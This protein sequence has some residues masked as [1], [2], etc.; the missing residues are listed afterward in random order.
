M[1]VGIETPI[2][3]CSSDVRDHDLM[4]LGIRIKNWT[5]RWGGCSAGMGVLENIKIMMVAIY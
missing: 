3:S 4:N 5:E 1:P 2:F